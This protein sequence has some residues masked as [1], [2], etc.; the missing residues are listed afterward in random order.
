MC[1]FAQFLSLSLPPSFSLSVPLCPNFAY[2]YICTHT[3]TRAVSLLSQCE[4]AVQL[5]LI[6]VRY[7]TQQTQGRKKLLLLPRGAVRP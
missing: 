6:Q 3:Y 2:I 4:G 7:V 5:I 1:L